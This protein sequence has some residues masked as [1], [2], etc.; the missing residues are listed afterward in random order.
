MSNYDLGKDLQRV[1]SKLDA[2]ENQLQQR[3]PPSG[4]TPHGPSI[5][6]TFTHDKTKSTDD[7]LMFNADGF[8]TDNFCRFYSST[9]EVYKT[10]QWN[11]HS[12]FTNQHPYNSIHSMIAFVFEGITSQL[13]WN[14][15]IGIFVTVPI[16]VPQ[17]NNEFRVENHYGELTSVKAYLSAVTQVF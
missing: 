14:E 16:D 17:W 5:I 3:V 15:D 10:G 1:L 7:Y 8:N 4:Q 13:I 2:I 9:L 11:F 12:S 6:S